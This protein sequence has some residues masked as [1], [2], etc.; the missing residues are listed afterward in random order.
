MLRVREASG[1]SSLA[2]SLVQASLRVSLEPAS[3]QGR[4]VRPEFQVRGASSSVPCRPLD[5]S[6][7]GQ[8]FPPTQHGSSSVP[9]T[10]KPPTVPADPGLNPPRVLFP[11]LVR[12]RTR[13][14]PAECCLCGC[15][16]SFLRCFWQRKGER[17]LSVWE[18]DRSAAP[19]GRRRNGARFMAP[20]PPHGGQGG[21]AREGKRPLERREMGPWVK[22]ATPLAGEVSACL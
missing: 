19:G 9:P 21:L 7:L 11:P 16:A 1:Q 15:R 17:L 5:C 2:L 12:V 4:G 10:P 14:A 6:G 3:L 18:R 22:A 20:E 13:P 8:P